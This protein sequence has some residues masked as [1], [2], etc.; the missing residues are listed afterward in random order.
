[1]RRKTMIKRQLLRAFLLKTVT[2]LGQNP[3]KL[4]MDIEEGRIA[5]TLAPS[6]SHRHHYTLAIWIEDWGGDTATLLALIQA[7]ARRHEP[8][9]FA[10]E[11]ARKTG[12]RYWTYELDNARE[13]VLV[14]LKLT[15]RMTVTVRDG[16]LTV[17]PKDE[18]PL[19]EPEQDV[20]TALLDEQEA[21]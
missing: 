7:W 17:T 15:E 14:H 3:E 12:F 19:P 2:W 10:T 13:K 21:P 8:D 11:E 5:A 9:I 16:V 1:K 6:L 20:L 4:R 18:I